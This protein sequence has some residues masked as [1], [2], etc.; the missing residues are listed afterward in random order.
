MSKRKREDQ[1]YFPSWISFS[2]YFIAWLSKSSEKYRDA[3]KNIE[4]HEKLI[5]LDD[6][7]AVIR[8][9]RR[10]NLRRLFFIEEN[11]KISVGFV[12][13]EYGSQSIS[14]L[15]YLDTTAAWQFTSMTKPIIQAYSE[16][17]SLISSSGDWRLH[18]WADPPATKD[19]NY[20]FR[21]AGEKLVLKSAEQLR[22]MYAALLQNSG[23]TVRP[24]SWSIPDVPPLPLFGKKN[25]EETRER[26]YK[27]KNDIEALV[28]GFNNQFSNTCC[29][30]LKP[31]DLNGVKLSLSPGVCIQKDKRT[32]NA[33]WTAETIVADTAFD[34]SDEGKAVDSTK[35]L[36]LKMKNMKPL[37][38]RDYY[39]NSL[40]KLKAVPD[41]TFFK[42]ECLI[43][44]FPRKKPISE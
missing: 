37:G 26:F 21:N 6:E 12:C 24:Y 34:F 1:S 25:E 38:A 11:K 20:L 23:F 13:D 32:I 16:Y 29:A 41:D 39:Y 18:I 44:A 8:E 43:E 33:Y 14:Y 17:I 3:L 2:N 36:I 27:L 5:L 15:A 40:E 19:G 31:P 35:S 9:G 42:Y 28:T 7:D 22:Q 10:Q 30:E 4:V